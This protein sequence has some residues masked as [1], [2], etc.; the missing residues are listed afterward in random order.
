MKLKYRSKIVGLEALAI[1]SGVF[2]DTEFELF[3]SG[4]IGVNIFFVISGC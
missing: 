4:Y 1:F 2:L 3:G